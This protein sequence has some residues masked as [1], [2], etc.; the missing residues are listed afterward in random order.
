M[1]KKESIEIAL[2]EY[3]K[4]DE[5][6]AFNFLASNFAED[7]IQVLAKPNDGS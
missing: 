2:E 6:K 3:I 1:N 4:Q 5:G 7:W